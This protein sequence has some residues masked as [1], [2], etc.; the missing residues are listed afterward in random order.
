MHG[1]EKLR[2]L[3]L[4]DLSLGEA[5]AQVA[6]GVSAFA[7]EHREAHL[8]WMDRSN[9]VVV[10]AASRGDLER[11]LLRG[12]ELRVKHSLFREPDR[13]NELTVVVLEPHE[14]SFRAARRL[15]LAGVAQR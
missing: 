8:R 2:I 5:A 14:E 11:V 13:D 3:V 6:H 12:K 15:P 7:R 1:S 10:H 4:R 9:T